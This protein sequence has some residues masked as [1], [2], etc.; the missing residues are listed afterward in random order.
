[1]QRVKISGLSLYHPV[2]HVD[3]RWFIEYY[4]K[5]GVEIG[6]LLSALGHEK[7]YLIENNT[8]NTLTMSIEASREV[9]KNRSWKPEDLNLIVF[10]SQTPEYLI[11][12]TAL[13]IHHA[14]KSGEKTLSYDMNANC[15]GLLI[16]VEQVSRVMLSRPDCTRALVVGADYLGAHSYDSPV[17]HA[18]FSDT[19]VAILLEKHDGSSG[20]IDSE[21]RVQTSVIDNSLFPASGLSAIHGRARSSG[22]EFTPFDDSVCIDAAAD[23]LIKILERNKLTTDDIKYFFLS[24]FSIGNIKK[25]CSALDISQ[26]YA[27][28]IGNQYGYTATNSPFVALHESLKLNRIQR[29]DNLIFWT[30]GAGWQ[31][32]AVLM[33][34]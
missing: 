25:L 2:N 11:P 5:K 18:C 32:A 24:Q 29:G 23:S 1:M 28:F 15:A 19:A 26:D 13:K 31:S 10:C 7:R 14:L 6:G 3:N 30:V 27:P 34:Y 22:I 9:L 20:M 16:A 4:D 8:E 33:K 12:A 17:Y 21:F